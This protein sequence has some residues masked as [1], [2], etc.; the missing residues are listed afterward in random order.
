MRFAG[1]R[2]RL[3]WHTL[4]HLLWLSPPSLN[5]SVGL[6]QRCHSYNLFLASNSLLPVPSSVLPAAPAPA[7]LKRLGRVPRHSGGTECCCHIPF[8]FWF[9]FS[10]HLCIKKMRSLCPSAAKKIMRCPQ[11]QAAPGSRKTRRCRPPRAPPARRQR[12]ARSRLQPKML[13][14]HWKMW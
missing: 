1:S 5:L 2:N 4:L 10:L 14:L 12:A 6:V 11:R 13:H 8:F 9:L 3:F 7:P